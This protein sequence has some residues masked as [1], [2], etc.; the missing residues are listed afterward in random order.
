MGRERGAGGGRVAVD[1]AFVCAMP[2][3]MDPLARRLGLREAGRPSPARLWFG[4]LGERVVAGVVTGM[5]PALARAGVAGLFEAVE[6]DRVGVVGVTGALGE[7]APIGGVV[8]VSVVIDGATGRRYRPDQPVGG[9]PAGALWTSAEVVTDPAHM[10]RL[11][12]LGVVALDMET[13]A[14]AEACERRGV[15]W[16]VFRAV[17]DRADDGSVDEYVLHLSG[18][19]GTP[20]PHAIARYLDEHPERRAAVTGLIEGVAVAAE[21]AAAAAIRALLSP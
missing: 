20:D 5:G 1:V 17:S 14:V 16:S 21:S 6:P 4:G 2:L 9:G 3:E 8:S 13:A 15:P 18:P 19:D 11:R 7:D 12:G 10:D